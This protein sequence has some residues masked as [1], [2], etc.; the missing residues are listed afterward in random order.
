MNI[1]I[2]LSPDLN[3]TQEVYESLVMQMVQAKIEYVEAGENSQQLEGNW[4]LK[5]QNIVLAR[6]ACLEKMTGF[7]VMQD[8]DCV[9]LYRDNLTAMRQYLDEHPRCA[10]V[11]LQWFEKIMPDHLLML[12][13]AMFAPI[14]F[15]LGIKFRYSPDQSIS[16]KCEC[17]NL[18]DDIIKAGYEIH[19]L[20]DIR[21]KNTMQHTFKNGI[22]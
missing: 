7:D 15:K 14:F 2:P 22:L 21:I 19:T 4:P 6:N 12:G 5:I 8:N 11:G 16:K 13:S 1:F 10:V 18:A 17:R 9:M 3:R 20:P